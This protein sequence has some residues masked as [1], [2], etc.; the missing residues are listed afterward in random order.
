GFDA[1]ILQSEGDPSTWGDFKFTN[2]TGGWL[3]VQTW[4]DFPHL[5]VEIYGPKMDRTVD[6]SESWMSTSPK[7]ALTTGFVRTVEDPKG[8]VL[9][10]REFVTAFVY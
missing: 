9:Y 2:D 6:I 7:G 8:A 10:E 4:T 5:I 1:S 3:L